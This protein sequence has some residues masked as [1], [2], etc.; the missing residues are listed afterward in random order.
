MIKGVRIED[1]Y[2]E[3]T[4]DDEL[5][6]PWMNEVLGVVAFG[7]FD[8][9]LRIGER[10]VGWGHSVGQIV[11]GDF[12][13]IETAIDVISVEGQYKNNLSTNKRGVRF[14]HM[15]CVR[16]MCT[17]SSL[18]E[19][20][21]EI[22]SL[23]E[24]IDYYSLIYRANFGELNAI[25]FRSTIK[26]MEKA[27]RDTMLEKS[28]IYDVVCLGES[29]RIWRVQKFFNS[30]ELNKLIST[31][32]TVVN[33]AFLQAAIP[34]GAKMLLEI[35]SLSL[36]IEKSGGVIGFLIK[37]STTIIN[38]KDRL[39]DKYNDEIKWIDNNQ[40]VE[41]QKFKYRQKELESVLNASFT[42]LYQSAGVA[43]GGMPGFPGCATVISVMQM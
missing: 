6:Q 26:P 36:G 12:V 18:N 32:G 10:Q 40:P 16:T 15:V 42:N 8:Q 19:A 29:T 11:G 38:D 3:C 7:I 2:K 17:L 20:S 35:S 34:H 22:I 30:K 39:M 21:I 43:P 24:G 28:C 25:L 5:L 9:T 1:V 14:P 33:G 13:P 37:R 23:F 31:G 27:L 4:M 41:Q